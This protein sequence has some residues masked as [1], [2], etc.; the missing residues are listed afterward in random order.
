M[1]CITVCAL[2]VVCCKVDQHRIVNA[3]FYPVILHIIVGI[4]DG[5]NI[6]RL[7]LGSLLQYTIDVPGNELSFLIP[8]FC[9]LNRIFPVS[10]SGLSHCKGIAFRFH[11]NRYGH[12]LIKCG[13]R[14]IFLGHGKDIGT[15][16]FGIS[17]I[18]SYLKNVKV[19]K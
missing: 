6:H 9:G 17:G 15:A 8:D 1:G 10:S 18:F 7:H 11:L 3:P 5:C 12:L 16:A 4:Y 13:Y 14:H 19:Q 2:I